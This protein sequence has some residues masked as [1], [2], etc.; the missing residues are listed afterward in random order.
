MFILCMLSP[1]ADAVE[2]STSCA[3]EQRR[4]FSELLVSAP[5]FRRTSRSPS[6]PVSGAAH[7]R[8]GTDK[9]YS[10]TLDLCLRC[11]TAQFQPPDRIESRR[12]G[13]DSGEG[14]TFSARPELSV[15]GVDPSLP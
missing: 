14:L 8:R 4:R 5:S 2:S 13:A 6:R 10:F 9:L 7:A 15:A 11:V 1:L 3:H 12:L